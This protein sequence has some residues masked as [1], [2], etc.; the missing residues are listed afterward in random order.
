MVWKSGCWWIWLCVSA[1]GGWG[2]QSLCHHS[3][4]DQLSP[5]HH[6]GDEQECCRC[7]CPCQEKGYKDYLFIYFCTF[8]A[9]LNLRLSSFRF[10]LH[11]HHHLCSYRRC[12]LRRAYIRQLGHRWYPL[13]EQELGQGCSLCH[14]STAQS[15]SHHPRL[16]LLSVVMVGVCART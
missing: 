3:Q 2:S 16:P 14:F 9:H 8:I 5:L 12:G 6:Q 13:L 4:S 10:F 7:H 11:W 15:W 1:G